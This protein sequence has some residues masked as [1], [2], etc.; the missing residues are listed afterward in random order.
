MKCGYCGKKTT[1]NAPYCSTY[2]RQKG[3]A[4]V[5]FSQKTRIPFAVT[6][7]LALVGAAIGLVLLIAQKTDEG[8]L[9]LSGGL[10]ISGIGMLAFPRSGKALSVFS[11]VAGTLFFA[12]AVAIFLLWR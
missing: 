8:M 12:V 5:N 6:Q 1:G 7:I 2:C 9:F 4:R 11:Q 3:E 10:A